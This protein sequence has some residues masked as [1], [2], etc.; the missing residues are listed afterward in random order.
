MNVGLWNDLKAGLA[1]MLHPTDNTK[2]TMEIGAAYSWYYRATVIPLI[3]LII[4]ALVLVSAFALSPIGVLLGPV[5][6][7]LSGLGYVGA[8]V[9]PIL[10]MW[11]LIP[12]GIFVKAGLYHLVGTWSGQFKGDFNKTLTATMFAEMPGAI[13][14]FAL[15]VPA[16]A[17][18]Y[19][20]FVVWGFIV[21]LLALANQQKTR[22]NVSL[23]VVLMT[24]V[25]VSA[26][27]G[28]IF[29]VFAAAISGV[30]NAY[31]NALIP[32]LLGDNGYTT[33]LT[34]PVTSAG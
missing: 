27:L 13:F 30:S 20:F 18:L 33:P 6:S 3:A 24:V 21:L 32:H 8:I 16:T 34:Y 22:W 23:G 14:L 12:I 15:V 26:V 28:V 1:V 25:V 7:A 31:I 9:L 17:A 11:V 29:T 5:G 4:V 2:K 10:F 19:F